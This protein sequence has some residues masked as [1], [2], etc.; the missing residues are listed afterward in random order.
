MHTWQP[1]RWECALRTLLSQSSISKSPYWTRRSNKNH[2]P[3][4]HC[5]KKEEA[6]TRSG[7]SSSTETATSEKVLPPPPQWRTSITP[8]PSPT[9]TSWWRPLTSS[10]I[11]LPLKRSPSPSPSSS[12]ELLGSSLASLWPT[13]ELAATE[14]TVFFSLFLSYYL[15]K[16]IKFSPFLFLRS[17]GIQ[18][19][20]ELNLDFFL[21]W[22]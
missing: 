14:L 13:T 7:I 9:R 6:E 17:L 16:N 22:I 4:Q 12:L 15:K 21:C 8:S 2:H 19:G 18:T 20:S 1:Q 5:E 11:A 10:T 3:T